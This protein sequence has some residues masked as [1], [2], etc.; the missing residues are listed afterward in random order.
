MDTT[1]APCEVLW[2][3]DLLATVIRFVLLAAWLLGLA[4]LALDPTPSRHVALATG[5]ARSDVAEFCARMSSVAPSG[6]CRPAASA[7]PKAS[8]SAQVERRA[9]APAM[10]T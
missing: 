2:V 5:S 9:Q 3:R 10:W 7:R 1:H 6:T 8:M 4:H